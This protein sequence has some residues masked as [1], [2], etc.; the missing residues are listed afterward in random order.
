LSVRRNAKELKNNQSNVNADSTTT[1]ID[2]TTATSDAWD[3][4]G[5]NRKD[6]TETEIKTE[7]NTNYKL[8]DYE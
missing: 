8:I 2:T 3:A 7:K 1:K 4:T 5:T 6:L